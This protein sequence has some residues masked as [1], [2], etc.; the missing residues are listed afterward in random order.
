M[1]DSSS[2]E[3]WQREV[4]QSKDDFVVA[5]VRRILIEAADGNVSDVHFQPGKEGM[6]IRFRQDGV[7][8]RIGMLPKETIPQVAARLKVLADL[9]TYKTN[10]PQEGRVRADRIPGI[11]KEVRISSA[12]TL[13]GE[14][15]AVRFFAEEHRFRY[16]EQL[17]L[18]EDI[19]T[20]LLNAIQKKSGALLITGPAGC[21]KTTTAYA[22]LRQLADR[23]EALRSIITLEDPVEHALDGVAQIEAGSQ[24]ELSLQELIKYMMR[25]DPEVLL[26]GEIRDRQT[27]EAALQA[28]LTGHLLIST[29]HAGNAVDAVGRL[30]ELGIEPYVL[31]SGISRI[32]SQRLVRKLCSCGETA[33]EPL[34]AEMDSNRYEF[35]SYRMPKGCP[36]C[37][38]TGYR[39]RTLIAE[40]LPLERDEVVR[41]LLDRKDSMALRKIAL[42]NG[43]IPL[44]DRAA[45]LIEA[46]TTSPLEIRRVFG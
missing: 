1:I 24:N 11:G 13:Y 45:G 40:S 12:P 17:G 14:R 15:L 21:G 28:S 16:P 38:G 26:V 44:A 22:L 4:R 34:F 41:S 3:L 2:L 31:R 32:L 20:S 29:F 37:N 36:E 30:F 43:M 42:K 8:H 25:Q 35:M 23:G 5:I 19:Q 7:L 33:R 27:A 39:G 18:S 9:L 6:E 10:V 46:G